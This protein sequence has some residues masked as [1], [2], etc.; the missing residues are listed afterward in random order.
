MNIYS[1]SSWAHRK[2]ILQQ[3]MNSFRV[4]PPI[5]IKGNHIHNTLQNS[6]SIWKNTSLLISQEI[7]TCI[8]VAESYPKNYYAWTHRFF[9]LQL[10][11]NQWN[12]NH[13]HNHNTGNDNDN[14]T[15]KR[16][17]GLS[18]LH[19]LFQ[20][21]IDSIQPWLKLHVSDHSCSH[22]GSQVL[23]LWL[24]FGVS[25][26]GYCDSKGLNPLQ[27]SLDKLLN[28]LRVCRELL[29]VPTYSTHEAVWRYRRLCSFLA[30]QL[31]SRKLELFSNLIDY[32]SHM[33][34]EVYHSLDQFLQKEVHD[35]CHRLSLS[36]SSNNDNPLSK[37]EQRL[38]QIHS[39][40]Y[41]MW[42]CFH[43]K[44]LWSGDGNHGL[45]KYVSSNHLRIIWKELKE[46]TS[47]VHNFWREVAQTSVQF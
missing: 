32:S 36:S 3:L 2:W 33:S 38:V 44:N 25:K 22:Y 9:C 18:I 27:W 34:S 41:L 5:K 45:L 28:A 42:I 23:H 6:N 24:I 19:D 31:V 43:I 46:D 4:S 16:E 21:E 11:L 26:G 10:F 39:K 1:P 15:E 17:I 14:D 13:N 12:H 47:I 37:E 40:S 30:I 8:S 29:E 20:K 7:Q 35:L